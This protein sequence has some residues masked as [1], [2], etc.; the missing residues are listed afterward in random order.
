MSFCF[1]VE[2]LNKKSLNPTKPT[3]GAKIIFAPF[4]TRFRVFFTFSRFFRRLLW[5]YRILPLPK[6]EISRDF[7]P[8]FSLLV[9]FVYL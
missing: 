7:Y 6:I 8:Y 1:A 9:V 2:K 3:I 4:F 5:E